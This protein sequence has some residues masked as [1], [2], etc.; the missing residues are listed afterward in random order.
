MNFSELDKATQEEVSLL[1]NRHIDVSVDILKKFHFLSPIL[2]I[3]DSNQI[4][5]LQPQNGFVDIDRAYA[6]VIEKLKS[7][8]FRYALFSYSTRIGLRSGSESDA[9]KTYIFTSGGTELTFYTIYGLKGIFKKVVIEKTIP[10][11]IK[12]NVF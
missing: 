8:S 4:I 5:S 12:E 7:E 3:P 6:Y 2:M 10:A 11:E 1:L 9:V